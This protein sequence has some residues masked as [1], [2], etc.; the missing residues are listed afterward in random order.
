M[1]RKHRCRHGRRPVRQFTQRFGDVKVQAEALG[2]AD[3]A[4]LVGEEIDA[5]PEES[6]RGRIPSRTLASALE[7]RREG[8]GRADR[9]MDRLRERLDGVEDEDDPIA[10]LA[11]RLGLDAI[12]EDEA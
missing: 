12:D 4:Q 6:D 11:D 10:A 8:F 9:L 3:W 1:R 7:E 2:Y 5:L